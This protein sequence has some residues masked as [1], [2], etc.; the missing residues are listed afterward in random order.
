MNTTALVASECYY[1]LRMA[2]GPI[3]ERSKVLGAA[4]LQGQLQL[5]FKEIDQRNQMF[6]MGNG[7][8]K[9]NRM[10]TAVI[11]IPNSPDLTERKLMRER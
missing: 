9:E 2:A 3:M 8:N 4:L 6:R 7:A 5:I 11:T 10:N 1:S